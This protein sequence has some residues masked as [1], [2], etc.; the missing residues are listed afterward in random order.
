[1]ELEITQ[2]GKECHQHCQIYRQVGMCVMPLEGVF[3]RI[4]EGGDVAA[5]DTLEILK[6]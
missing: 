1:V 5:G 6:S 4:I 2:I 3:A